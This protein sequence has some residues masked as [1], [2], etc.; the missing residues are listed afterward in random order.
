MSKYTT[1]VRYICEQMSGLT[2]SVG[3]DGV[4]DVI[5]NAWNKVFDFDFPIFDENYRSV[6]CKK[7]LLHYYTREISDETVG[8]WKTHLWAKLNL[9]MPYYNKLYQSALLEFNPLYDIEYWR[10]TDRKTDGTG[11][12]DTTNNGVARNLYSDTPQG[13]LEGV[14]SERY[15]T[16]A[17]KDITNSNEN[18]STGFNNTDDFLEHVWGKQTG[19]SFS[20]LLQEYRKTFIN[21]DEQIIE[22]LRPL[23]FNLW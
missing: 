9:I 23:F 1:E 10:K 21:I 22:E 7:I 12:S 4:N 13:G 3:Y 20:K 6:L 8:L 11:T 17:S 2:D 16:T 19:V 18:T 14:E 15:L 5:N